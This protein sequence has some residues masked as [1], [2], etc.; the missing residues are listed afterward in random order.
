MQAG[1]QIPTTL[2]EQWQDIFNMSC[3]SLALL[4]P[5]PWKSPL[6]FNSGTKLPLAFSQF[7]KG[8]ENRTSALGSSPPL[9][10]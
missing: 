8:L 6:I 7:P 1:S 5:N 9:G 2:P 3:V 4:F 10:K